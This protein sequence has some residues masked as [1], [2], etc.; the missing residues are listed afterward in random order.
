MRAALWLPVGLLALVAGY[1]ALGPVPFGLA[2]NGDF[3]RILGPLRL[4]PAAPFRDDPHVYFRYF[5]NDYVEADPRYETGVPSSEWLVAALAKKIARVILPARTFQLRLLG[6]IH[7]AILGLAL[8]IF[9]HALRSRA[10]WLRWICGFQ[11]VFMWTDLEYVQQLNTAYTDA[12]AVVALAVLFSI[13]VHCLLADD[14]LA[15]P[16]GFVLSGCFLLGTKT[17]HETALP[18]LV[19]FCVLAGIR[20][21]RKYHRAAW[22]AAP[23]LLLGTTVWMLVKTPEDY[24]RGPAFTIVFFKLAVLSPDPKSVLADF[25][26]PE[27]EFLKY[28]GHYAYQPEVPMQ[29]PEFRRRIL[30]LVTPSSLSMFY[31]RHPE[32]LRTVLLSDLRRWAPDVD[33]NESGYGHLSESDV[34]SGRRPFELVAWSRFRRYLFTVAPLH[35]VWLFGLVILVSGCCVLSPGVGDWLPVWPITLSS[36]LLAVSS[37]LF[38]SLSE[39]VET[40]RHLVFF[41]AATDLTIFSIVLSILLGIENRVRRRRSRSGCRPAD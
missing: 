22:L 10:A 11:L 7:L 1:Q 5:V 19:A 29:D 2:N 8:F 4:W 34:R 33:L 13:A 9:L 38:A 32:M 3:P 6:F 27:G 23:I 14:S 16:V 35:P 20:A 12:G 40:A 25:R 41:Q 30:S 15:L 37:F 39:A 31:W 28:V 36:E 18:F 21:H 24:R 17:Q 26:M